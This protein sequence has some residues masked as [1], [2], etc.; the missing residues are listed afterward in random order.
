MARVNAANFAGGLQFPYATA[1]ADLFKKEDIQVLAQAVDQHTHAPGLGL[2]L[3][4]GAIP[5]GSITSA[6]I[7]DGTIAT[8]DIAANAVQ[9]QL[10][11]YFAAPSFSTTTTGVWLTTPVS[12][13]RRQRGSAADRLLHDAVSQCGRLHHPGDHR[14]QRCDQPGWPGADHGATRRL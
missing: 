2:P 3:A 10:G 5:N 6:M 7:A 12:L 14:D 13:S 1:P 9:Q 11:Q 8:A 4:A